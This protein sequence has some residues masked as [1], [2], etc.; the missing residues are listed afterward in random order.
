MTALHLTDSVTISKLTW[1]ITN[2]VLIIE[3][4][5]AMAFPSGYVTEEAQEMIVLSQIAYSAETVKDYNQIQSAIES[6]L[7]SEPVLGGNFQLVWLG[8]S[9]D[10]SFL[11]FIARDSRETARYA[12]SV[13]GTDISY[14]PDWIDDLKVLYTNPWPTANPPNSAIYVSQGAGEVLQTLLA[15]TSN[16]FNLTPPPSIP[17]PMSMIH[18]FMNEALSSA[19]TTD[20]DIFVT[21]HS[22]GGEMATVL[23]LWLADTTSTWTVR[24]KKVNL[25]TYTFAAPTSG[26]QAFA[27]YYNSQTNNTQIGWQAYRVYNEQD[28]VPYAFANLGGIAENGVPVSFELGLEIVATMIAAQTTLDH[29]KVSYVHVGNLADGTAHPLPNNPPQSATSCTNPATTLYEYFSCWVLYEHNTGTYMSLLGIT[30]QAPVQR[31]VKTARVLSLVT[32]G[33]KPSP[34]SGDPSSGAAT[35]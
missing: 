32:A 28:L 17:S 1:V 27:D 21:G 20:L 13:R 14:P 9:P 11:M 18:L 33:A 30:S 2:F 4:I 25:K 29:Y 24:P 5:Y 12:I 10:Y 22:L 15:M 19:P 26:N 6:A 23:G 16:I 35:T 8:I 31:V 7:S 3:E 34:A